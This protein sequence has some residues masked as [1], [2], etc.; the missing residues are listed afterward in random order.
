MTTT[1][2][3]CKNDIEDKGQGKKSNVSWDIC[4][5]PTHILNP[6]IFIYLHLTCEVG[7]NEV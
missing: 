1:I 6:F 4:D 7:E 5:G 2:L 3:N